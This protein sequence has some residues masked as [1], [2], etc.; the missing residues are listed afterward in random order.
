MQRDSGPPFRPHF[1]LWADSE[2]GA[3]YTDTLVAPGEDLFLATLEAL[4]G[5]VE[6]ILDNRVCPQ[7]LEVCDPALAAYL[8]HRLEGAG[9]E[10]WLT[11]RL[12]ML[13]A[14][15]VELTNTVNSEASGPP[16]PPN[17][18]QKQ[19]M[20][21]ERVRAF[22]EAAAAFYR[23]APW[24]SLS[25][26]DL[27]QIESPRPPSGFGWLVVLGAARDTYGLAVYPSR[28]A[29]ERF[30]RAGLEGNYPAIP[31]AGLAH[32]TFN[33]FHELPGADALLWTEHQLPIA[34]NQAYPL[35]MKYEGGGKLIRPSKRELTFLEGVL[36]AL[37]ATSEQEIDAGRW[38]KEI[39]TIDGPQRLALAIPDLLDPPTPREWMRRGFEPD[40][41][42]HER[43]FAD[44]NRYLEEHPPTT[45][46]DFDDLNRVFASRSLDDPL[47][48][49]RTPVAQA[50][51]VCFQA[52]ETYGRRRVQLARQALQLEPNCTDA[53]VILAE[54]AGTLEDE[55]DHYRGGMEAAERVLGS[56]FFVENVGH[57]WGLSATRPYM[58]AR[59]GLAEALVALGRVDEAIEHYQELL[60]LNP[61]DNQGIRYLLLPKLLAVG[62]DLDAARLLK[63]FR[64]ESAN[65]AYA[66]ALLAFR[67]SS[68]SMAADRELRDAWHV[69]RHV[70]ELVASDSPIPRPP[71]Y[72]PGSYEEAC[73]AAEELRPAFQATPGAIDW[74]V[75]AHDQR[76]GIGS[77]A[78]RKTP[79]GTSQAEET[80]GA[81]IVV[82]MAAASW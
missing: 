11:D 49:P 50:Q 61:N 67:L 22:A 23:A 55:L 42:A 47:T 2:S 30:L 40:R 39:T 18:L 76:K 34:G 60:R 28:A 4:G 59:C 24:R 35:V 37:A 15:A 82:Q 6:N 81:I 26:I 43:V 52:F 45:K 41:R 48:Q 66:Q 74:L 3:F 58:R 64:E 77:V 20:T 10:I 73:V 33:P 32:V 8:R 46:K 21:I 36:R 27:I 7:R 51:D 16:G 63:E 79:Q 69:N 38:C 29:Y 5:Y 31:T 9:I 1:P 70:P 19:G 62:R 54:Q 57:F 65:W 71:H 80:Q 44:M 17:L 72:A 56:A 13:E 75:Q 68:R 78:P 12:P 53:H 14:A 25:D